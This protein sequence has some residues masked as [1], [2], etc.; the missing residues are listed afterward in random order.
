MN[1]QRLIPK[2]NIKQLNA[3][4]SASIEPLQ[5]L[6]LDGLNTVN[7]IILEQM[8]SD[9]PLI[10]E[11][12][13]HLIAA[14]GKRLRPM[15]TLACAKLLGYEGRRH[16][17]LAAC[18]EFIHSATLLHDDVVDQSNLRRGKKTANFIWGNQASV[19]VGD[20]LFSRAFEL[21]VDDG[22][23]RVF[24]ILSRAS[25][26]IAEGEVEQLLA[27]GQLDMLED[28][29]LSIIT[30]KTAVLFAA[31]CQITALFAEKDLAV[32]AALESF[33]RNLGIAF[34]LAD[35]ALDYA[36][37]EKNLRKNVG[38]DFNEGKA[39]LPVLLLYQRGSADDRAF[40]ERCFKK[41]ERKP[42]DLNRIISMLEESLSLHDTFDRAS[43]FAMRARDAIAFL[44]NNSAKA[45]LI[46]TTQFVVS[47]RF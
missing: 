12:A 9:V 14:G 16:Y 22:S 19:L 38:D 41:G 46:E 44:P 31:A 23:L 3:K 17:K 27:L 15:L 42:E 28:Q 8:Q 11:M 4:G 10:S 40:L 1:I 30:S 39:T 24:K 34:Q 32:E 18:I 5:Q 20:Y 29:Y 37:D 2:A 25:S 33:G 36:S 47:R 43:Y 6:T 7:Q 21:M 45:A 13:G 35:D 26:V